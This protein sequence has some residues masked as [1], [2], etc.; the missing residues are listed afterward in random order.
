MTTTEQDV[1]IDAPLEPDPD[2]TEELGPAD[3]QA[4]ADG[5]LKGSRLL[6]VRR[7]IEA[8]D[9]DGC[10]GGAVKLACTFQPAE[11]CRFAS[12]RLVLKL[13]TPAGV[14]FADVQPVEV[15]EEKPVKFVLDRK[16]KLGLKYWK[17]EGGSEA[18]AKIEYEIYHCVVTGS[19]QGTPLARWDFK[20][21]PHRRDGLGAA[22]VL[23][24]TIPSVGPVAGEVIVTARLA[25]LGLSGAVDAIRDLFLRPRKGRHYLVQFDI[26]ATQPSPGLLHFLRV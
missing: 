6:L 23:V 2:A 16:G 17:I 12:A 11:N 22:H 4:I 1:L 13:T 26:P 14:R 7:A 10:P 3:V 20:E 24:F 8:V 21:N 18:G 9:I 25:R 15:P 19:G 5:D